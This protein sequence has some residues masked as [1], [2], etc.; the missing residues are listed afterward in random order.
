[1]DNENRIDP[2]DNGEEVTINEEISPSDVNCEEE[3]VL[4]NSDGE[5]TTEDVSEE[6]DGSAEDEPKSKKA[7]ASE[8]L[9][10]VYDYVEILGFS[11]VAVLLI[12]TFCFRLCQVDGNSM[13]NTLSDKEMVITTNIFY[14]PSEGDIIVFHAHGLNNKPVVK[15]VVAT[16]G[17]SVKIDLTDKKVYVDGKLFDDSNTYLSDGE[18]E[19]YSH[20]KQ[21]DL[22]IIPY[23]IKMRHNALCVAL[24]IAFNEPRYIF[25]QA[26]LWLQF[27]N[28]VAKNKY[29]IVKGLQFLPF[30]KSLFLTPS[31]FSTPCC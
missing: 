24:G 6:S 18:Y 10:T 19:K 31:I 7:S 1:M 17:Q 14:T 5:E 20:F 29:Q 3:E 4:E 30:R 9:R 13:L 2:I 16:G 21:E 11:V 15:R 22:Y 27:G 28:R 26:T 8:I 23:R 12:F 25:Q